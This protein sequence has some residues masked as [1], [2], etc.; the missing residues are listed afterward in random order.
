MRNVD[1]SCVICQTFDD[2]II[3]LCRIVSVLCMVP[4]FLLKKVLI[5]GT[6]PVD[7]A[8][9]CMLMKGCFSVRDVTVTCW[10]S[11]LGLVDFILNVLMVTLGG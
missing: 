11:I 6:L 1:N 10:P 2:N 5:G 4:F 8:A 7:V 9:R 3:C